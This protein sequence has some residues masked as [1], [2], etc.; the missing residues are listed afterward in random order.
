[1][2]DSAP[3]GLDPATFSLIVGV[4]VAVAMRVLDALLPR[5]R[6]F[7]FMDRFLAPR[8]EEGDE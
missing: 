6:S 8:D 2:G 5:G 7:K 4:G 1:M 3:F